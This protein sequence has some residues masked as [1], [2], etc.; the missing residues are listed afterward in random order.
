MVRESI[1]IIISTLL[2]VAAGVQAAGPGRY[3]VVVGI[4]DYADA[5]IPDLKYAESDA[6][7]VYDTLTDAKIGRFAKDN[8]ALLLGKNVTPG[9][10]KGALY[11]LRGVGKDDLVVIFYSGH[12]AKEGDEAF[13]VTQDADRKALPATSL[14]NSEIRKYFQKIPSQRMVVLLD[15]CYA[16]STVKKSLADP[17]KLFGEFEGKGRV[18]IAGSSDNQEALEYPDKKAGVFTHYLVGGLRGAADVNTDGVVTFEEIWGYLGDNVRKASVKQGGLHEPVLISEGGFTPQFLLT[19]NPTVQAASLKSVQALR[20]LFAD[21]KISGGQFDLGRKVLSAPALDAVSKAR[22]EV[23]ASLVSGKLEPKFL[24]DVL[25]SRVKQAG[26]TAKPPVVQSGKKPTLAIAPF[27]VL[28]DIKV[29]DAGRILAER[30]LPQFSGRYEIIDQAELSKFLAQDNLSMSDLVELAGKPGTKSLAKAVRLRR[31]SYLVVGS[32]SGSPGGSLS[33]TA[34]ICDW[35]RGTARANRYAQVGGENWKDLLDR[36]PLLSGRLTGVIGSIGTGPEVTLPDGVDALKARIMQLQAVSAQFTKARDTMTDVNPRVKY[37]GDKLAELHAP[38]GKAIEAKLSELAET[39]AKLAN[40]YKPNHPQRKALLDEVAYLKSSQSDVLPPIV[41]QLKAWDRTKTVLRLLSQAAAAINGLPSDPKKLTS[42]QKSQLLRANKLVSAA[43]AYSPTDNRA[44]S[45]K[46]RIATYFGPPKKLAFDFGGGVTMDLVLIPAGKFQMGSDKGASDEK[47]VREVTIS[48][49][50]YMGVHEVTQAQWKAVMGT[51]P[52]AGEKYAK[53]GAS[54]AA[55]YISWDDAM[56]F[57]RTL[58]QTSGR[59]VTLPTE[60]QWEYACRAGSKTAY[61]FGDDESKLGDYAWYYENA[62]KK[63]EKYAH[64]AGR[65]KPN[66]FGLYDMHGNV[67]EWCRDWYDEKFYTKAK[68]VDPENTTEAQCRVLRGGSWNNNPGNCRA[69]N[70]N[71]NTTDNRNNNT[72]FR[73]VVVSGSGVHL[74]RCHW[75]GI[76]P[77]S[78]RLR[79]HGA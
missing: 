27:T 8:V 68:N 6:K 32:V 2:G 72:G 39:D 59:T 37:L 34:R 28:G 16:A 61:C 56:K 3:A 7:A 62:Y 43:L 46:K 52:W 24:A 69:A 11:K 36:L 64:A 21:D 19:F 48:K 67:L 9:K 40:L 75:R 35:Q 79:M 42:T 54:H 5:A 50:F 33:I 55:S 22:R 30:L 57:C 14:T 47:P 53:S 12:G 74:P 23:F 10:I 20:K 38:I 44:L 78:M 4:N 60:A 76:G 13:W 58:S 65:K 45:L 49:P 29:K 26:A 17:K 70:R 41:S 31:V 77:E 66:A 51:E 71:R 73:V 63:D 1:A 25:A 15:C 18:T